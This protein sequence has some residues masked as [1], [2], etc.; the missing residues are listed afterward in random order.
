MTCCVNRKFLGCFG[1]C[2]A[3]G[4]PLIAG[5]TGEYRFRFDFNGAW[6]TYSAQFEVGEPLVLTEKIN[7]A[8][9]WHFAVIQPDGN[10]VLLIELDETGEE[11]DYD[12]FAL[13]IVPQTLIETT[14]ATNNYYSGNYGNS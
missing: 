11:V 13:R 4:L 9:L 12:C 14:P 2:E 1:H 7:E 8:G 10:T 5:M 3:I 6:I